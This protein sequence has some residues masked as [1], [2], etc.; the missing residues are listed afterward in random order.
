MPS[1][2]GRLPEYAKETVALET[3][4]RRATSPIVA[5]CDDVI[6]HLL[7]PCWEVRNWDPPM[8]TGLS[9]VHASGRRTLCQDPEA[10]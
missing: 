10:G 6:A 9:G 5:L 7:V 8:Q 1:E 3:P 2:T 4:A